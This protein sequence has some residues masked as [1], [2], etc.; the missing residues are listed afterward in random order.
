MSDENTASSDE[1]PPLNL[2]DFSNAGGLVVSLQIPEWKKI[3]RKSISNPK[4][5][6]LIFKIPK[7]T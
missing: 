5:L 2:Q 7:K 1:P 4:Q 3:L 6:S